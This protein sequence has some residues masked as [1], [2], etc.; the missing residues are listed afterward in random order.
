MRALGHA[1]STRLNLYSTKIAKVADLYGE[2]CWW[3]VAQAD[4]RMRSARM[5]RLR[6]RAEEARGKALAA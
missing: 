2:G 6:R 5:E 1:T 4:A 3:L